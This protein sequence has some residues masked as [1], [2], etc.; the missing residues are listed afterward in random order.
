MSNPTI[1]KLLPSQRFKLS[2]LHAEMANV[3]REALH[4]MHHDCLADAARINDLQ[5]KVFMAEINEPVD[6][7]T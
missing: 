1:D 3:Y 5:A 7:N 6:C 2:R 4:L